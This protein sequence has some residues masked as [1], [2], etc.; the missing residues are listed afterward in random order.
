MSKSDYTDRAYFYEFIKTNYAAE[1][2]FM[3]V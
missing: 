2:S 3:P 1:M